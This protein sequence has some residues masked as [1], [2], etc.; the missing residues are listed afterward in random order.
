MFDVVSKIYIATDS[1]PV[2]MQSYELCCDMI[3][4]VI[5]LSSIYGSV[6]WVNLLSNILFKIYYF[7]V[8][9]AATAAAPVNMLV[10]I[11]IN[12]FYFR[13]NFSARNQ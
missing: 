9:A 12:F 4:V 8:L 11:K 10:K 5:D 13:F 3:D 6:K 7:V 2:D 1:S